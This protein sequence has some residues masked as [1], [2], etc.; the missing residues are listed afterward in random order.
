MPVHRAALRLV[1][2]DHRVVTTVLR[3]V[4]TIRVLTS[5]SLQKTL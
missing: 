1:L 3:M 2:R 4:L 5:S